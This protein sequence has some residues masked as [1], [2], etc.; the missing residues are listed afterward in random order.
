[1]FDEK[2][3]FFPWL[4]R[5]AI[6]QCYDELR[7]IKRQ[8]IHSFSELSIEEASHI[9]KL[10]NQNEVPPDAQ[11]AEKEMYAIMYKV[12]DQLPEQQKLS[13]TLRDIE[14]VPYDKMAEML[15]CTEQAARLKVFRARSR[16]K[17]LVEKALRKS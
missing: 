12:L 2:R 4:Y 13:I 16:L 6:N 14:G 15:K 7:R 1:K 10:I 11:D 3:P 8:R 5:I 9:E 17:A